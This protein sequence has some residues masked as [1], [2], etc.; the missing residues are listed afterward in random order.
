MKSSEI[1]TAIANAGT[2]QAAIAAYLGISTTLVSQVIGGKSRSAR[3]EAELIK[4]CGRNPF[5]PKRSAHR[6]KTVWTGK[7]LPVAGGAA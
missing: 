6:A 7:V 5:P 1:K 3:V 2:S 4:I